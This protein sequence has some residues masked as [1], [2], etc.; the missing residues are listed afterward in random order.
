M[1]ETH[2]RR[3]GDAWLALPHELD[4]LIAAWDAL[5][6][7]LLR[8]MPEAF[9]RDEWAY[10]IAFLDP[11]ALRGLLVSAFGPEA[12]DG[13]AQ[14]VLRPRGDAAVWLPNNV[15]LLGPLMLVLLSIGGCRVRLKAGSR[16]E[17]LTLAFLELARADAREPLA[18]WL[19]DRVEHASFDHGDPRN[20]QLASGTRVQVFFGGDAGAQAVMNMSR[21]IDSL[22]LPFVDRRSE[23]WLEPRALSDDVLASLLRV[24]AIYGQAGCTSPRRVVLL[25]A[26]EQGAHALRARLVALWPQVITARRIMH[27]ASANVMAEQWARGLGW[28]TQRANDNA[29][30]IASGTLDLPELSHVDAPLLLPIVAATREQA[31]ERLPANVQTIG[32]ALHDP[33]DPA[34]IALI[35]RSRIARFVPLAHMHHFGALWDGYELL[36]NLFE[37]VEVRA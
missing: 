26:D 25:D 4:G 16:A 18:S 35:A 5:R 6:R 10:L 30:V 20:A 32:H 31:H 19:R 28:Q 33:A 8:A 21:P 11:D 15:S 7:P 24:F 1:S 27:V 13:A 17:D 29:A 9:T 2:V 3:W 34:W 14:R 12:R 23:A 37:H 36:R 22:W